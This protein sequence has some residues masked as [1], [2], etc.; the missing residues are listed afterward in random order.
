MNTQLR[1]L[2]TAI[3][4]NIA[5]AYNC[6]RCEDMVDY[7][8]YLKV[9]HIDSKDNSKKQ[10]L[11]ISLLEEIVGFWSTNVHLKLY[12]LI[13]DIMKFVYTFREIT[14]TENEKDGN[15]VKLFNFQM[16]GIFAFHIKISENHTAKLS[17][18]K[19][20]DIT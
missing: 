13:Q 6:I 7:L 15:G 1:E 11:T 17:L 19:F 9:A 2:K 16:Y 10:E 3:V 12:F 5:I 20:T 18:G 14:G 8:A 4:K